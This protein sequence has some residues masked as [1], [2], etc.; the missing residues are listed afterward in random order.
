MGPGK[1]SGD[2][3]AQSPSEAQHPL[4]FSSEPGRE[5]ELSA[6]MLEHW[7]DLRGYIAAHVHGEEVDDLVAEVVAQA[8]AKRRRFDPEVGEVGP[9]L[10][11][12]AYRVLQMWRRDMARHVDLLFVSMGAGGPEPA[13]SS[14]VEDEVLGSLSVEARLSIAGEALRVLTP[15]QRDVFVGH[16]VDGV[17][18]EALAERF[19]V[20]ASTVRSH[21]QRARVALAGEVIR[22][23]KLGGDD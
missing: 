9:W 11:G 13:E 2:D 1:T 15:R 8:W 19:G 17:P 10:Q 7:N 14:N 16:V 23:A 18:C 4:G 12:F 20:K 6:V 22:L 21:L 3:D 5:I